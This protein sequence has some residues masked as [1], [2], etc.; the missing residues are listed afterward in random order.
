MTW[1]RFLL[2]VG[3][4]SVAGCASGRATVAAAPPELPRAPKPEREVPREVQSVSYDA[5]KEAVVPPDARVASR[6]RASV[7]GVA[8]L[9]DEVRDACYPYLVQTMNLEEPARTKAQQEIFARELQRIIE[10]EI[11]LDDA[12]SKLKTRP[13]VLDKLKEAASKEFDKNLQSFKTRNRI[14]S[15]EEFKQVLQLQGMSLE[16]MRRQVERSFMMMEYMRS[17]IYPEV[18]KIGHEMIVDYY[19]EHAR[20]FE[21]PE[22]IQWQDIFIALSKYPDRAAA[23]RFA[24]TIVTKARAGEDWLKLSS[25]YDDGDSAYRKGEGY[26]QQRGEIKPPEVEPVLL[27]MQNGQLALVEVPN[28]FH[29]IRLVK[30][31]VAGRTPLDEKTQAA[32]KKKLQ[33]EVADREYK[34]ILAELKRKTQVHIET[35]TP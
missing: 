12:L 27:K 9:D 32:I 25:Q 6:V 13:Q 21:A 11:I 16:G 14:K 24:D 19:Q 3:F 18:E 28:G 22:R 33:D 26:G 30:H 15:D 35:D 2:V 29:V 5:T 1:H 17:R 8:I 34:R 4:V 7:N 20:E 23:R 31:D 10:R